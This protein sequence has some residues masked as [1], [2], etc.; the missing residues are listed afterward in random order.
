MR[1]R[2]HLCEEAK[3]MLEDLQKNWHFEIVEVDIDQDDQLVE[4]YGITIPVIEVDG[5][6]VQAGIIHKKSIIEAFTR[7]NMNFIS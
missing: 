4:E 7:K 3:G 2:C 5:E 1:Q 6:E